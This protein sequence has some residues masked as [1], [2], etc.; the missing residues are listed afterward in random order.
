M[1]SRKDKTTLSESKSVVAR[2]PVVSLNPVRGDTSKS[3][4]GMMGMSDI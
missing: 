4:L 2:V 3:D 1:T